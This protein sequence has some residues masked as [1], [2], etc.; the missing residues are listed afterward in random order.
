MSMPGKLPFH[1]S[2]KR[3]VGLSCYE[4]NM[5]L[6]ILFG[7]DQMT[8]PLNWKNFFIQKKFRELSS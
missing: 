5:C 8:D 7:N 3:F 6:K 2:V 4:M 1:L